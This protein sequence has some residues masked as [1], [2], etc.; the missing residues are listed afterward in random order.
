MFCHFF[1]FVKSLKAG[2]VITEDSIRSVR[3]GYGL[4]PKY[5]D[6]LVGKQVLVDVDACTPVLEETVDEY[7]RGKE[8]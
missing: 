1:C 8:N 3:P 5:L 4:P 7:K 2:E 6:L